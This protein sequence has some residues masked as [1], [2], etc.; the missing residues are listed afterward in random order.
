MT[1]PPPYGSAPGQPSGYSG[2]PGQPGQ[3]YPQSYPG[4]AS[5]P[6]PPYGQQQPGYPPAGYPA[7]GYPAGGG[8]YPGFGAPAAQA[9]PGMVTAAAV[10]A[11]VFGGFAII[12]SII[13]LAAGGLV[14]AANDLCNSTTG[15]SSDTQENCNALSGYSGFFK[16]TE[17]GLIIV[18]I[19][20]IW[21]GVTTLTGKNSQILVI[22][23][24]IYIVLTIVALIAGGGVGFTSILGFV[25]PI[26]ILV[27][28]FNPASRAWFRA[29]G[30]KTF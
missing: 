29:K 14:S 10:L 7:A 9:R 8:A 5:A 28:L 24:G 13:L 15:L 16:V 25:A 27:F 30:G 17:I 2:Q 19:L 1:T 23:A 21:G 26:L 11:F 6:Q 22:G 4:P 12:G 18:A 20:L 3:P